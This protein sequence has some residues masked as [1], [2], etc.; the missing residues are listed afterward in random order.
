MFRS[1]CRS[2]AAHN[3]KGILSGAHLPRRQ[4]VVCHAA[5]GANVMQVEAVLKP[6]A[7][8]LLAAPAKAA[9]PH[10]EAAALAGAEGAADAAGETEAAEAAQGDARSGKAMRRARAR[11][12]RV[13]G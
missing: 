13:P 1:H 11:E 8:L 2:A 6:L 7:D 4:R 5:Q 10:S 9:V 3:K 12:V